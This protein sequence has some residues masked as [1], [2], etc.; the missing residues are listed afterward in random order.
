MDRAHR[1]PGG[2][3]VGDRLHAGG[4]HRGV[5]VGEHPEDDVEHPT[6]VHEFGIEL[7]AADEWPE[8]PLDDRVGEPGLGERVTGGAVGALQQP[9]RMDAAQSVPEQP[10]PGLVEHRSDRRGGGDNVVVGPSE[11]IADHRHHDR[12]ATPVLRVRTPEGRVRAMSSWRCI[13]G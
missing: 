2:E 9:D 10:D 8:E 12:C 13:S 6:A 4:G 1:Q 7:D 11:R 3:L 5:A